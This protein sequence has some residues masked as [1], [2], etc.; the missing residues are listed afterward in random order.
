MSNDIEKSESALQQ[1]PGTGTKKIVSVPLGTIITSFLNWREFNCV[2]D[3]C[4]DDCK[5]FDPTVSIW[6]PCDGRDITGSALH[7]RTDKSI[8]PDLRG[9][10]VRG[11]NAFDVIGEE[12]GRVPHVDRLLADP[13]DRFRGDYQEDEF[14]I[15]THVYRNNELTPGGRSNSGTGEDP[16]KKIFRDFETTPQGGSETRPKNIAAF[17]YIRIN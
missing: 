3:G 11:L 13:E 10:F 7:N 16:A 1:D 17:Y 9:K 2:T 8:L 5:D 4:L 12:E 15:H 14:K 6:A